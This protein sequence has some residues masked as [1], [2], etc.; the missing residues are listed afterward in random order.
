MF[1]LD[2][3]MLYR[4]VLC[5]FDN[6]IRNHGDD[7]TKDEWYNWCIFRH[8]DQPYLYRQYAPMERRQWGESYL[9]R[10]SS[11]LNS[12]KVVKENDLLHSSTNADSQFHVVKEVIKTAS[13]TSHFLLVMAKCYRIII[14][15][16]SPRKIST[17]R[18]SE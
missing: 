4:V 15:T 9:Y 14:Y 7:K 10:A 6:A 3:G 17:V 2:S 8:T 1:S 16:F 13:Y 12:K 18:I 5:D 11:L